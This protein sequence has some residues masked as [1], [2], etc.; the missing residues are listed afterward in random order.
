MRDQQV[1]ALIE[2]AGSKEFLTAHEVIKPGEND[3]ELA[4]AA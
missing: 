2:V 1:E 4:Q 3:T